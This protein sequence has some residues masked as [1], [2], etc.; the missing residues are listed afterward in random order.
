[1][2]VSH[3]STCWNVRPWIAGRKKRV[4]MGVIGSPWHGGMSSGV[5]RFLD[6]SL[7]YQS[8]SP[9]CQASACMKGNEQCLVPACLLSKSVHYVTWHGRVAVTACLFPQHSFTH[10]PIKLY[11][12]LTLNLSA[13]KVFSYNYLERTLSYTLE[14]IIFSQFQVQENWI[15]LHIMHIHNDLIKIN[16]H[17]YEELV[18]LYL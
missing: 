7:A 13:L 10:W 2:S 12:K 5:W 3:T 4:Y 17:K 6:L 11:S 9:D 16:L 15:L 18:I 8:V 14:E 1:M